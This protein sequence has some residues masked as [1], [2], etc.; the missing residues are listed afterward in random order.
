LVYLVGVA[1]GPLFLH[2]LVESPAGHP[3]RWFFAAIS[4]LTGNDPLVLRVAQALLGTCSVLLSAATAHAIWGRRAAVAT[5]EVAALYGPLVYFASDLSSAIPCFFLVTA[6]LY[7]CARAA[8]S[9]FRPGLLIGGSAL[10]LATALAI[11]GGAGGAGGGAHRLPHL[12]SNVALAWN[13]REPPCGAIDQAF[14]ASFNSP[15]FRLPWL[16]SFALVGPIALVA[17]WSERRRAPLL[18]AYLILG[19]FAVAATLVCDRTRL[20]V[21]AAAIPLAGQGIDRLFAALSQAAAKARSWLGALF[22]AAFAHGATLIAFGCATVFVLVPSPP[23]P[24]PQ[25]G[26]GWVAVARAYEEAENPR[27]AQSA[28][29][30]AE[31]S[32]MR[33]ADFYTDWG[34]L[35]FEKRLG[36]LA[37]QHLLTAI[38]LDPG[39]APAHETLGEVYDDQGSFA[40]A[41]QEYAV[42]AG[43]LPKRAAELYT[44]A[45]EDYEQGKDPGRAAEMFRA[46]LRVEPGYPAAEAGLERIRNPAPPSEPA[47]MF[48]P[49][50]RVSPSSAR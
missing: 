38:G 14:F 8:R 44:R 17:A 45:G 37:D 30:S 7:G 21:L 18:V 36:I 47:K 3:Y 40:Q 34:R 39:Y 32:G 50:G 48:P 9:R 49:L 22:Q 2:P 16:P 15:I 29:I 27:A 46:A 25:A 5:A 26:A 28:Y 12:L 42:A 1:Q 24:R 19:T 6:A 4:A 31:K 11:A 41:G 43:L 13:W 20:V 35:E 33:S 23:Y 10:A